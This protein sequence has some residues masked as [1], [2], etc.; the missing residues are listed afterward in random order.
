MSEYIKLPEGF[1]YFYHNR[2]LHHLIQSNDDDLV[3]LQ[4]VL[5]GVKS[6]I[7]ET[8]FIQKNSILLSDWVAK[9]PCFHPDTTLLINKPELPMEVRGFYIHKAMIDYVGQLASDHY[10][11]YIAF[12]FSTI[13]SSSD[14]SDNVETTLT[15]FY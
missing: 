8:M 5:L 1:S 10:K 14:Y 2:Y 6:I 3:Q 12:D 7:L 13:D 15:I 4:S 11:E 9:F